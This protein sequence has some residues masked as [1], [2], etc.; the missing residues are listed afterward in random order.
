MAGSNVWTVKF[1]DGCG[2]FHQAF[3]GFHRP[4][5]RSGTPWEAR[6]DGPVPGEPTIGTADAPE[7]MTE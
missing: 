2:P 7:P 4:T 6:R 1:P 3:L 5:V